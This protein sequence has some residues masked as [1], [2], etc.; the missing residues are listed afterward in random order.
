[1]AH[2]L[3]CGVA[4]LGALGALI[5]KRFSAEEI[6]ALAH[7][8]E[9]D[10]LGMQS[11]IQDQI[12]ATYGGVCDIRISKYPEAQV[13]QVSIGQKLTEDLNK[14][15]CLI[16][17]GGAHRSSDIH[18]RVIDSLDDKSPQ[19]EALKELRNLA[20]EGKA[21][22]ISEDLAHLGRVMIRNN[23]L[24]RA[25]HPDLISEQADVVIKI[26]E[27]CGAF[28]WKVNGAGGQGG[29]LTI[30]S[31]QDRVSRKKMITDIKNLGQGIQH[32]Q[33]KLSSEGLSV[34]G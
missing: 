2:R 18:E 32:L 11:G 33:V 25:L 9:T 19:A 3:P 8:V 1:L 4:L 27:K 15:L 21:S 6:A 28:G 16:Y 22:L 23:E 20:E 13:S 7:Q 14:Q 29:S 31:S 26:A 30:L 12:C 34:S 5:P 10:K 17:L 24:Q